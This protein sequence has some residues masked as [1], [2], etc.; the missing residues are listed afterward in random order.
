MGMKSP[1]SSSCVLLL[2]S[3][4]FVGVGNCDMDGSGRVSNG[5]GVGVEGLELHNQPMVMD[6]QLD[7]D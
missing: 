6:V 3:A 7:W 4:L 1:N 5:F 2:G